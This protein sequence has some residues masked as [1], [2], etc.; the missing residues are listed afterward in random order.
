[1]GNEELLATVRTLLRDAIQLRYRGE[2]HASKVRAQAYA[3]GYMRALLDAGHAGP[4][5]LLRLVAAER[6]EAHGDAA[7]KRLAA[8]G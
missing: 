2:L 4:D 3:D 5:E 1:M 6:E 8:T 7:T